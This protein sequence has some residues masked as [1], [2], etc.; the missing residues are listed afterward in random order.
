VDELHT[1]DY[2]SWLHCEH[3]PQLSTQSGLN[4]IGHY[5]I[6][7][8]PNLL[9]EG[10]PKQR[11]ETTEII[12]SGSQYILLESAS[13]EDL[14]NPD[15]VYLSLQ[16]APKLKLR[17]NWREAIFIEEARVNGPT[18]NAA[19][20]DQFAPPAM[21]LGNFIVC[22][23]ESEKDLAL[24]YRKH[25]FLQVQ[26]TH[27]C[28][29]ARKYVSLMGWPKHGIFYEFE[30]IE[31]GEVLFEARMNAARPDLK[32]AG[33]HPLDIVIHAPNAPHAGERIWP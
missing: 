7:R 10:T 19:T 26:S 25:R 27:G 33:A 30:T 6:R 16:Q 24:Y 18:H 22:N 8:K 11:R 29:G 2:L 32:W 3:L 23:P 4:W 5:K 9:V 28:R 17:K 15:D 12:P 31:P 20:R 14:I 1:S 13:T 21:Q